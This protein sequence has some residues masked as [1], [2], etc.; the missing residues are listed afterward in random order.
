MPVYPGALPGTGS[1]S[2]L[3]L[4][5]DLHIRRID[6]SEATRDARISIHRFDSDQVVWKVFVP[7]HARPT[8][9]IN[10]T[11]STTTFL[12][13]R[14]LM[15]PD[16]AAIFRLLNNDRRLTYGTPTQPTW[17][18][19]QTSLATFSRPTDLTAVTIPKH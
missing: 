6:Q 10:E 13:I 17:H 1:S 4:D 7:V 9:K 19:K 11:Q 18:N 3:L 15:V 8:E 2:F 5:K 16:V 12:Y 14:K